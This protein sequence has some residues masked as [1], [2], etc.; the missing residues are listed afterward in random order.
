MSSIAQAN[1][2]DEDGWYVFC[3]AEIPED[4]KERIT[5]VRVHQSVTEIPERT[6]HLFENLVEV[7]LHQGIRKL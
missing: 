1:Y 6:F 4:E 2:M 7:Q 3:G 5:R